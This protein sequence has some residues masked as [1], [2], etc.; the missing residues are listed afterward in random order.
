MQRF[1]NTEEMAEL[2]KHVIWIHVNLPGQNRH[3]ADLKNLATIDQ[4]A[5]GLICIIDK[6]DIKEC[7]VFG[8]GLGANMATEFAAKYPDRCDGLIA[9]EPVVNSAGFIETMKHKILEIDPT[10]LNYHN[11]SLLNDAFVK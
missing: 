9:I 10:M 1:V 7:I 11:L 8:D 2:C 3:C 4:L 6:L 5:A